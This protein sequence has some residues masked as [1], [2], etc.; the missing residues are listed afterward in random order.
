M[1]EGQKH[2]RFALEE[3]KNVT[4]FLFANVLGVC[5]CCVFVDDAVVVAVVVVVCVVGLSK[6]V[7]RINEMN[8]QTETIQNSK[9]NKICTQLRAQGTLLIT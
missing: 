2:R 5:C 3:L 9:V 4:G 6:H 7:L 1:F 8:I